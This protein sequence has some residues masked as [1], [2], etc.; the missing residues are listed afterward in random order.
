MSI[1]N[2]GEKFESSEEGSLILLNVQVLKSGIITH[3]CKKFFFAVLLIIQIDL[4]V[5]LYTEWRDPISRLLTLKEFLLSWNGLLGYMASKESKK[6]LKYVRE[7]LER[8]Q[9]DKKS[10]NEVKELF[11]E[12]DAKVLKY[13]RIVSIL[14]TYTLHITCGMVPYLM[15]LISLLKSHLNGENFKNLP[16]ILHLY[17]PKAF[18]TSLVF[19]LV[20]QTSV[21]V[22]YGLLLYYW[23]ILAK[24]VY[25][26]FTCLNTEM[27]LFCHKMERIDEVNNHLTNEDE[28]EKNLR[29]YL[30]NI[31]CEHQS[32]CRNIEHFGKISSKPLFGIIN[33]YGSQICIYLAFI[34]LIEDIHIKLRYI[35]RYLITFA[36]VYFSASNGQN[37]TDLGRKL[38][39]S[40]F[41]CS[42]VDKPAWFRKTLLFMNIRASKDMSV[43]PFGLYV[44]DI[45][46]IVTVCKGTYTYLNFAKNMID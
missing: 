7:H 37:I 6:L 30:R 13:N 29:I 25:F 21:Y 41:E 27:K 5:N 4:I 12:R 26:S 35:T 11:K 22:W 14:L 42:W 39:L 8:F 32:I 9:I 43:K 31:V 23:T 44:L 28:N 19:Q 46:C 2:N 24:G 15:I 1:K 16:Q 20:Y 38:R 33:L 45:G 10:S 34:T 17:F 40:L 3:P 36:F 18:D